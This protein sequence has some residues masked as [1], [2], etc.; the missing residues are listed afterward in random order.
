MTTTQKQKQKTA[1]ELA[2]E[3]LL[4]SLGYKQEFQRAFTGLEVSDRCVLNRGQIAG[5][6]G[7]APRASVRYWRSASIR[8]YS[9]WFL[10]RRLVSPSV[11]LV[12]CRQLRRSLHTTRSYIV[13]KYHLH[14]S[15]LVYSIPDGGPS[16]MVWGVSCLCDDFDVVAWPDSFWMSSG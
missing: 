3:E 8:A 15:V 14:S 10:V 13:L 2:D 12:S 16:A 1:I 6:S 4:A 5:C 11:S 9:V 7:N